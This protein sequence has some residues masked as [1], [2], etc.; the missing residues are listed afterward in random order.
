M[1]V[2]YD[3]DVA[4]AIEP[5][6]PPAA[7]APAKR[8][9]LVYD[10]PAAAAPPAPAPAPEKS[11]LEKVNDFSPLNPGHVLTGNPSIPNPI[12]GALTAGGEGIQ[13]LLGKIAA[14]WHGLSD[15]G[16]GG[17]ADSAADTVNADRAALNTGPTTSPSKES[18]AAVAQP[19]AKVANAVVAPL[20]APID[21]AVE[22]AGP[23]VRTIVPAAEEAVQDVA[24]VLPALGVSKA[25]RVADA[26]ATVEGAAKPATSAPLETARGA[27]YQAPPS[28]V[29]AS[30]PAESVPGTTR[31]KI[32]GPTGV[33]SSANDANAI[34]TT[35]LAGKELGLPNA[36]KITADDAA[37]F[38]K[39][40]PGPVYNSTA[41]A[42]GPIKPDKTAVAEL[43]AATAVEDASSALSPKVKTEVNRIS[44]KIGDGKYTG[45]DWRKDISWL[46]ENGGRDAA[47]SLEDMA[48]RQLAGGPNAK[49]LEAYRGARQDFA[50]SYDIQGAIGRGGQIDAQKLRTL[51]D[52]YP[53]ILTGNLKTIATAARELPEVT[54]LPGADTGPGVHTKL[55]AVHNAIG[56]AIKKLPGMNPMSESFQNAKFGREATPTEQSYGP[57]FGRRDQGKPSEAFTL[58]APEGNAAAGRPEQL[59]MALAPGPGPR[60]G[61]EL[62]PPEG[63]VY[64]PAQYPYTPRQQEM[65]GLSPYAVGTQPLGQAMATPRPPLLLEHN[66]AP[67]AL[68]QDAYIGDKGVEGHPGQ[69]KIMN[70]PNPVNFRDSTPSVGRQVLDAND[71]ELPEP[72]GKSLTK[73]KKPKAKSRGD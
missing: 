6:A 45:A 18:L 38:R 57:T 60:P 61:L 41:E 58:Q 3:D 35:K 67:I 33:R 11:F 12:Q 49:A 47:N 21:R 28:V 55:Q 46:R 27:G 72:L 16:T 37:A 59:G 5:N 63:T 34:V 51:D 56:G 64:E 39:N 32:I 15:L 66:P 20:A 52:K 8:G 2:I 73:G 9:R 24:T 22:N 62:T 25:A 50:K 70:R 44:Q 14:G 30:N 17:T 42:L 71:G 69:A 4:P 53:G 19:V 10:A 54:T 29:Q 43:N 26:A 48:E 23:A 1:A 31:E 13:N 36:T 7:A 68:G 40:G 65:E